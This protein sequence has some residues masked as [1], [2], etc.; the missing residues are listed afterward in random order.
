M[1][2]VCLKSRASWTAVTLKIAPHTVNILK[3]KNKKVRSCLESG[4]IYFGIG[5]AA[6]IYPGSELAMLG[7][8]IR[9]RLLSVLTKIR[10]EFISVADP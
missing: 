9:L 5:Y 2:K 10:S 4:K 7:R 8:W 6:G 1:K 3:S